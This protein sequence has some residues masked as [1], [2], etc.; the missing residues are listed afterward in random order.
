MRGE[1]QGNSFSLSLDFQALILT[2]VFAKLLSQSTRCSKKRL[3]WKL[4]TCTLWEKQGLSKGQ[5][6]LHFMWWIKKGWNA[7]LSYIIT[8]QYCFCVQILFVVCIFQPSQ[9]IFFRSCVLNKSEDFIFSLQIRRELS[10]KGREHFV[11]GEHELVLQSYNRAL[12]FR[13]SH[14]ST[15]LYILTI[16]VPVVYMVR[17]KVVLRGDYP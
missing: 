17:Y 16:N 5:K 4:E 15:V 6:T 8:I 9:V 7:M 10:E 2:M 1:L 3:C 12:L 14:Y 11:K 13:F